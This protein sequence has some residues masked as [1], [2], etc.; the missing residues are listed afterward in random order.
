MFI[1][2]SGVFIALFVHDEHYTLYKLDSVF[3]D[4]F[5]RSLTS[6]TD[7]DS[8]AITLWSHI[9]R[10]SLFQ[11]NVVNPFASSTYMGTGSK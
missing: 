4:S 10:A 11:L 6:I 9:I 7:V 5:S 2:V 1:Q 8:H 3:L